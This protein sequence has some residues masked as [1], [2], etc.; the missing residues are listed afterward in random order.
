MENK[1]KTENNLSDNE[2][3][4]NKISAEVDEILKKAGINKEVLH[5]MRHGDS[6]VSFKKKEFSKKIDLS[7]IKAIEDCLNSLDLVVRKYGRDMEEKEKVL[8]IEM[9]RNITARSLQHLAQHSDYISK[10]DE[11]G[12]IIPQKI[13]NVYKEETIL[14]YENKFINTLILRLFIFVGRRYNE[15]E[16]SGN[17]SVT[18]SMEFNS[19]FAVGKKRGKINFNIECTEDLPEISDNDNSNENLLRR[20]EKLNSIVNMY[21]NSRFCKELGKNY[22]R[23]P[24]LRTNAILKNRDYRQCLIL[25]QFIESYDKIGY[26]IKIS[27]TA[28]KPDFIYIGELYDMLALQYSIYCYNVEHIEDE[29]EILGTNESDESLMPKFITDYDSYDVD[30]FNVYDTEYRKFVPVSQLKYRRKLS[31]EERRIRNAIDIALKADK[32]LSE[33]EAK[34]SGSVQD[35]K[36]NIPVN[37]S[38]SKNPTDNALTGANK[39]VVATKETK[40]ELLALARKLLKDKFFTPEDLAEQRESDNEDELDSE[41]SLGENEEEKEKYRVCPFPIRLARSSSETKNYYSTLKNELLSYMDIKSRISIA[42]ESFRFHRILMAKIRIAGKTLKLYLA[43]EPSFYDAGRYFQKDEGEIK[44][45]EEVKLCLKI[46][47]QRACERAKELITALMEKYCVLK[48]E[49]FVSHDYV[50][51]FPYVDFD[52]YFNGLNI[53]KDKTDED[54]VENKTESETTEN[55]EAKTAETEN[56]EAEEETAATE[57]IETEA[58]SEITEIAEAEEKTAITENAEA[59]EET[60]ATENIEAEEE[61]AAASAETY[62]DEEEKENEIDDLFTFTEKLLASDVKFKNYY[63]RIK[64]NILSYIGVKDK[65]YKNNESFYIYGGTVIKIKI[66]CK[67]LR[68]YFNLEPELYNPAVMRIR[69]AGNMKAYANLPLLLS[70]KSENDIESAIIL[71]KDVMKKYRTAENKNFELRDYVKEFSDKQISEN[72]TTDKNK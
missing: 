17:N 15:L 63:N 4:D 64:N 20:I 6:T 50:P 61:T 18:D 11:D 60:A 12:M 29:G 49:K 59:E 62:V 57:N 33:K 54:D 69:N 1:D 72:V 42:C 30:D 3:A 26:E 35:E 31:D 2:K 21:M 39:V 19:E 23:P 68:Y 8:P 32:I 28:E 46:K 41:E 47:S 56:A 13:L 52:T 71:I 48:D 58:K 53:D 40:E 16:K 34:I 66:S 25:W 45:Y 55:I 38:H 10:I 51:E 70:V 27:Q 67:T 36:E 9:S 24:I 37:E 65:I 43:L 22:V 5:A 14:T 7:W 44:A